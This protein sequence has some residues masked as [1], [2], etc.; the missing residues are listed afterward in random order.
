MKVFI[1]GSEVANLVANYAKGFRALGLETYTVVGARNRLYP[2]SHYDVVLSELLERPSALSVLPGALGRSVRTRLDA[3]KAVVKMVATCDLFIYNTG[4]SLLPAYLDYRLIKRAGKKLVVDFLGSEIRHWYPYQSQMAEIGCLDRVRPF[5]EYITHHHYGDYA[6]MH[7]RVR[8]AERWADLILSQPGFAQL[9]TRPYMRVAVPLD[10]AQ[11]KYTPQ[12]REVP[13]VL[14]AP[15]SRGVKGTDHVLAAVAALQ[16]EGLA[17][18]F[19]LIEKMSHEALC[20]LLE[21]AD[22]VVDELYSDTVGVLS[23]EAMATGNVVLT[24]YFSDFARVPEG[25]PALDVSAAT[26]TDTL[27]RVITDQGLRAR[28]TGE[29]RRYVEQHNDGTAIARHILKCVDP[30]TRPAYDFVPTFHQR[31]RVPASILRGELQE[32]RSAR[33]S[34]WSGLFP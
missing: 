10:L 6:Q 25:C 11:L 32:A 26:L 23:A 21:E 5:A 28:L 34:R 7:E 30:V 24:S 27:R 29:G 18:E 12:L 16:G 13:L 33:R 20:A 22:I 31:F 14:H 8:Q 2:N 15:T 9:Q 17:F 4:G 1:G 3:T 19:R